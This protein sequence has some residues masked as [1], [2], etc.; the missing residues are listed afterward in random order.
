MDRGA[1]VLPPDEMLTYATV[2]VV[3]VASPGPNTLLIIAHC[4]AGGRRSGLAT[5]AGVELGTLVHTAAAAL[6]VSAAVAR[7]AVAFDAVR[8]A[9]GVILLILGGRELTGAHASPGRR[10]VGEAGG[11]GPKQA[12]M[13]AFV[14]NVM[15][16]K[17]AIFFLA[18]LP[19]WV[20]PSRG[21]VLA[22]FVILGAMLSAIGGLFGTAL[23]L[24][25]G[26]ASSR[27][28]RNSPFWKWQPRLAGCVLIV[29]GI[30][31]VWEIW[32]RG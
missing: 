29:L 23:A 20:D 1:R 13:R 28:A 12:L 8:L 7:S 17:V 25:A 22:Q 4:L 16:P 32:S 15:N 14:A 31:L 21:S 3:L 2:V 9:G 30:R 5:V 26:E 24:A 6:G 18:F 19:Q 11:L 10:T 27:L